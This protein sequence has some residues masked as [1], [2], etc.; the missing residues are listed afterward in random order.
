MPR[1]V[2]HATGGSSQ[3][4]IFKPE[5]QS[6]CPPTEDKPRVWYINPLQQPNGVWQGSLQY[7]DFELDQNIGV[8][9]SFYLRKSITF[10]DPAH[11]PSCPS[12][13]YALNRVEVYFGSD[14]V[15]TVYAND[16]YHESVAF[17]KPADA[18]N[19][20]DIHNLNVQDL[21]PRNMYFPTTA[22]IQAYCTEWNLTPPVGGI[23]YEESLGL[24]QVGGVAVPG[25]PVLLP[26]PGV[27]PPSLTLATPSNAPQDG[28]ITQTSSGYYYVNLDNTCLKAMRPYVKGFNSRIK[29]RCYWATSW[30]AQQQLLTAGAPNTAVPPAPSN[31]VNATYRSSTPTLASVQLLVEEQTTDAGSL[32]ALEQAHRAGIVD[33]T[34]MIRERLQDSPPN[35]VG[36]QQNTTFLRAFRNKSA[37]LLMYITAPQPPLDRVAQRMAFASVQL[38]DARGN[39]LTEILDNDILTSKIFPDQ[40]DSSFPNSANSDIRT[41]TLLPFS[42]NFQ[43]TYSEG[44]S[45]GFYQTTTLEQFVITPDGDK[46]RVAGH[47]NAN[48]ETTSCGVNMITLISYSYA[49]ITC[50]GGNHSI[51]FE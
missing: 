36:G 29:I 19:I 8:A 37:G 17:L 23:G 51:R 34:V 24:N 38:L 5:H 11:L 43:S 20:A 49:H 30:V 21:S 13:H 6:K 25:T 1:P 15:E 40:I 26:A 31:G 42:K 50:M 44:C 4:G 28:Q 2:R 22:S 45:A 47:V 32:M 3:R 46:N 33:Y 18:I 10:S 41:I 39:K 7:T 9:Q 12:T 35:L 27:V 16:L 14:L 48:G